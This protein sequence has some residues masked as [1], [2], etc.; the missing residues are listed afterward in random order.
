M[1]DSSPSWQSTFF[2]MVVILVVGGIFL[3]VFEKSGTDDA[4]KVWGALGTLVGAVV[5]AVPAY[6]FGQQGTA[7]AREEVQRTHQAALSQVE[8][9]ERALDTAQ[10]ATQSAQLS[11]RK[12]LEET[13]AA[14]AS[15]ESKVEQTKSA[16]E[17]LATLLSESE[18]SLLKRARKA[19][20]DLPW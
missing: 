10:A 14:T 9:V 17:K 20:P 15:Q 6:F 16:E 11:E 2:A 3:A 8:R 4:I 12:A 13:R 5:G 18:P 1:Q 7:A 19:R